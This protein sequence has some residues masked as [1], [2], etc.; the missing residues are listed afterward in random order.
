M[1]QVKR[2]VSKILHD[3]ANVGS[4]E[5]KLK[6]VIDELYSEELRCIK[7]WAEGLKGSIKRDEIR[8]VQ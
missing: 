1:E 3:M 4:L 5:E 6:H 7:E 2:V 8:Y